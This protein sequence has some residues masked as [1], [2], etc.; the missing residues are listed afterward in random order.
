MTYIDNKMC[1]VFL[2]GD[3]L[4]MWSYTM[5]INGTG[6]HNVYAHELRKAIKLRILQAYFVPCALLQLSCAFCRR[7]LYLARY[8]N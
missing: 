8:F 5:Y 4:N 6:Q 3:L 7:I 2:A 1:I